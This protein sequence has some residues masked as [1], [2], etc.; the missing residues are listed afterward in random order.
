MFRPASK[1]QRVS[2]GS[3]W[4]TSATGWHKAGQERVGRGEKLVSRETALNKEEKRT[5]N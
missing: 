4:E 3:V 2:A 1:K 5:G